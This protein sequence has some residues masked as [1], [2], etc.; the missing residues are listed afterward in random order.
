MTAVT[1][2]PAAGRPYVDGSHDNSAFEQVFVYNGF[3][4][5]GDQTPLQLLASQTLGATTV[6]KTQAAA[7]DRL[8][9]GDLGRDT[10]W[11]LPT[12]LITG[13]W[14]IVSRP[15]GPA[16]TRSGPAWSCGRPG[17]SRWPR[18]SR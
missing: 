4:R 7:P 18:R 14:G 12:A 5:F 3:G 2:S 15:H 16:A 17:W 6:L 10:G 13:A 9:R 1:L 8:L 11:L